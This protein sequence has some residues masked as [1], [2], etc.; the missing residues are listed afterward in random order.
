MVSPVS[1]DI[2]LEHCLSDRLLDLLSIGTSNFLWVARRGGVSAPD[3][4]GGS[5]GAPITT[6]YNLILAAR[7]L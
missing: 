3:M 2:R 4:L 7:K 6:W 1:D 5:L